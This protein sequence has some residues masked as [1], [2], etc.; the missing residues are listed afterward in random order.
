MG[1]TKKIFIVIGITFIISIVSIQVVTNIIF[2]NNIQKVTGNLKNSMEEMGRKSSTDLLFEIQAELESTL[3]RGDA[4]K[5]VQRLKEKQKNLKS[6]ME[7]SFTSSLGKIIH[8]T[9]SERKG[10]LFNK[11]ILSEVNKAKGL[12]V[13]IEMTIQRLKGNDASN[14]GKQ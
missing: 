9:K 4:I 8:S 3:L 14:A 1:I 10:A 6:I 7:V 11:E 13:A 5:F 12:V 2:L